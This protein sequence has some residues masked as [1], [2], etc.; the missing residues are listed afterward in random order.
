[1]KITFKEFLKKI[2][3]DPNIK[4]L[5]TEEWWNK[6]YK[7]TN[8]IIKYLY[9]D[10]IITQHVREFLDGRLPSKLKKYIPKDD[11][12]KRAKEIHNDKY[13]YS[14]ITKEWWQENYRN[15]YLK[16]PIVCKKHGVFYQ[17]INNHL[18]GSGCP[19]CNESKGERKIRQYLEE[20]NIEYIYQYK[21]IYKNK[22]YYFDFFIPD[23]KIGIE[24]D[25]EFHYLNL[26]R[27]ERF[28]DEILI[29]QKRD[30]YKNQYCL[31][32]NIKLLRIPYWKFNNIKDILKNIFEGNENV[33]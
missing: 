24:Y 5:I 33:F 14:L 2:P 22:N 31:E 13:D 23:K 17:R 7:N 19:K 18:Y 28:I 12:L 1:M 29:Q 9:I 11:F 3:N 20:N 26:K 21:I 8:T 4:L 27:M 16:L 30:K 10:L 15:T 6:N 25:G 32:N